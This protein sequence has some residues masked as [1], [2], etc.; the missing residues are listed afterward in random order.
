MASFAPFGAVRRKEGKSG[1]CERKK[2][3]GVADQVRG[4]VIV[5][6]P[7]E[8]RC[9]LCA[10]YRPEGQMGQCAYPVP[11]IRELPESV[12]YALISPKK[13]MGATQGQQCPVFEIKEREEMSA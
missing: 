12:D 13:R 8:R 6:T 10:Y 2:H 4:G 3:G 7:L 1:T 11:T 9:G 5:M